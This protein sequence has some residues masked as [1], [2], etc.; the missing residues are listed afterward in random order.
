[1]EGKE[2]VH[3]ARN[4]K[5]ANE[6]LMNDQKKKVTRKTNDPRSPQERHNEK[7][8]LSIIPTNR[9]NTTRGKS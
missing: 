4:D 9:K 1:M 8:R 5:R 6:R 2:K 7:E 3:S